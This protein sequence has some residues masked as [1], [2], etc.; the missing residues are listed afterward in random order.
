MTAVYCLIWAVIAAATAWGL[1]TIRAAAAISRM[2]AQ[3]R[4]EITYWQ[5]ETSRARMQ[6]EQ[7]ARDAA[8]WTDAWKR[9][10]DDAIAVIPLITRAHD[11][12]LHLEPAPNDGTDNS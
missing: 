2:Q 12:R 3:K 7:S 10:R 5:D 4:K 6:A 11:G 8:I 1:A 9:G